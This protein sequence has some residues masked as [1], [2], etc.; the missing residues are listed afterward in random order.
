MLF[1]I[2]FRIMHH[3]IVLSFEKCILRNISIDFERVKRQD[4]VTNSL[5]IEMLM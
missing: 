1:V 5:C 4:R 3:T 2:S